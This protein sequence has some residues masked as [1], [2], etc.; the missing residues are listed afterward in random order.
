MEHIGITQEVLHTAKI[1]KRQLFIL[2]LDLVK[3]FDRV[4][5]TF[6]R[7]VLLQIGI[8]VLGVNWIMSYAESSNFSIPINGSPTKFF[9]CSRG[10]R[11]GCPLSP[12]LFILTI[13]S[14]SLLV[15]QAHLESHIQGIKVSSSLHLTHLLFVDDVLLFGVGTI[16]EWKHFKI[17]LD[18]F[19]ST[20]GMSISKAKSSFL[21]NKLN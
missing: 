11:Q 13:E 5:W 19:C 17:L 6:L 20:M 16:E 9:P 4:N 7:L 15:N 21:Y 10:I 1:E 18:L 3:A 8:L 12:L 14:L 2:K